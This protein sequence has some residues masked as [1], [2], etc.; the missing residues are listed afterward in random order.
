M[1]RTA[2]LVGASVI[3]AACVACTPKPPPP[4]PS[5]IVAHRAQR[6]TDEDSFIKSVRILQPGFDPA[7]YERTKFAEP[8]VTDD[9]L[10]DVVKAD[11]GSAFRIAPDFFRRD[12]CALD[13]VFINPTNCGNGDS[14]FDAS[15]GY[16][17]PYEPNKGKRYIA[18][19]LSNWMAGRPL[20]KADSRY[21]ARKTDFQHAPRLTDYSTS[22]LNTLLT[23][24]NQLTW[25]APPKFDSKFNDDANSPGM[26]VLAVL[27]HELGHV[28]WYDW[29]EPVPGIPDTPGTPG[30]HAG[31]YDLSLL[32]NCVP[33]G[34]FQGSWTPQGKPPKEAF[35]APAWLAFGDVADAGKVVHTTGPQIIDFQKPGQQVPEGSQLKAYTH[36]PRRRSDQQLVALAASLNDLYGDNRPWASLLGSLSPTE[37][38]VETYDLSVLTQTSTPLRSLRLNISSPDGHIFQQDVVADLPKKP[39][40]ERKLECVATLSQAERTTGPQ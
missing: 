27:A 30:T 2:F 6:C 25:K 9:P 39:A 10:P 19:S 28:R 5:P 36:Q 29:V 40:L 32:M 35:A 12:V 7:D 20:R 14:C 24:L 3:A 1:I 16:R 31:Y 4:A 17:S 37:D 13:G 15:W 21:V 22:Q 11:L 18:I 33:G 8:P 26:T 23:K 34:F 38:L